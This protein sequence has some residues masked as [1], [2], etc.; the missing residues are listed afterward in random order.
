MFIN[1]IVGGEAV[2]WAKQKVVAGQIIPAGSEFLVWG[3]P[4][5]ISLTLHQYL[6]VESTGLISRLTNRSSEGQVICSRSHSQLRPSQDLYPHLS[7]LKFSAFL[8]CCL[9]LFS[10]ISFPRGVV[11][12]FTF[13]YCTSQLLL[14]TTFPILRGTERLSNLP[15]VTQ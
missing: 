9:S 3:L 8:F 15:K 5:A 6:W 13:L 10:P 12:D 1:D 7:E 14:L 11:P 2:V 4:S